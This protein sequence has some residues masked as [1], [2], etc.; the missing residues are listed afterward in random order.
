MR[1]S[2]PVSFIPSSARRTMPPRSPR[3]GLG[4]RQRLL[5][6]AGRNGD[7]FPEAICRQSGVDH[8]CRWPC[9]Q[10]R[11]RH[12]AGRWAVTQRWALKNTSQWNRRTSTIPTNARPSS[13]AFQAEYGRLPSLYAS[14]GFRYGEPDPFGART[15]SAVKDADAFRE[16]LRSEAEFDS[17]R[18]E[19]ANWP[20]TSIRCR[21]IYAREVIQGRVRC[22]PT[23]SLA[24]ALENHAER[25][26]RA[27][28]KM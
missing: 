14:Q 3:S 20:A 28:C 8:S 17:T 24:T 22:L 15:R 19:F 6:P 21:T 16:A 10:L 26:R 11:P 25:L 23:R 27:D 13:K 1:A 7:F 2:L 4:R 18:G 12:F 5:L 9:I